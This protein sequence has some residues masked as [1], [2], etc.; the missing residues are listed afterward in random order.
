MDNR[1]IRYFL[2]VANNG[3]SFTKAAEAIFV[4]QPSLT[5]QINKLSKEIGVKLF[6]TRKKTQVKLTAGGKIMFDF[7][8]EYETKLHD[9]VSVA[10]KASTRVSGEIKLLVQ[11]GVESNQIRLL[12]NQFIKL[13]PDI[14]VSLTALGC[15]A[16]EKNILY[17][18][19]D[20]AIATPGHLHCYN[21][22]RVKDLYR[23]P[24]ILLFSKSHPLAAKKNLQITDFKDEPF[25]TFSP[26]STLFP[27]SIT[28]DYCMSKGFIPKVEVMPNLD[29]ILLAIERDHGYTILDEW[30]RVRKNPGYA[31][32][33][34]DTYVTVGAI[35]RTNNRNPALQMFLDDILPKQAV[36]I[37]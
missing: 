9:T 5:K 23:V 31:F 1:A 14:A 24:C 29:S 25:F 19:C 4:S 3:C 21:N 10:K 12:L 37:S 13:H 11:E 2:A 26:T 16:I 20:L 35:W 27:V 18:R 36:D 8:S 7:F 17:D 30:T 32:M 28:Q 6:D 22:V 33:H 34:L 15:G